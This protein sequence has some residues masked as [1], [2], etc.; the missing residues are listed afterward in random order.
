MIF[1]TLIYL[2]LFIFFFFFFHYLFNFRRTLL[3]R[4]RSSESTSATSRTAPLR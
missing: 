1:L 4:L 2:F 3:A